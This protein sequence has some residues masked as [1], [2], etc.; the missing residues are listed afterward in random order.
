MSI[1]W[2]IM[3]TQNISLTVDLSE[4]EEEE[5]EEEEYLDDL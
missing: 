4:E 5:E 3:E 1:G 2:K